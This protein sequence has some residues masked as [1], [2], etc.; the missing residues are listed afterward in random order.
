[1]PLRR[2]A[3]VARTLSRHCILPLGSQCTSDQQIARSSRPRESEAQKDEE[4]P[5]DGSEGYD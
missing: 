4:E 3:S 2:L 1:V 5:A